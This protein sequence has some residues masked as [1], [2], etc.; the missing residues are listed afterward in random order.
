MTLAPERT[1]RSTHLG[2]DPNSYRSLLT[3]AAEDCALD[4]IREQLSSWLR[5]RGL[6]VDLTQSS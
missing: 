5:P 1:S 4:R 6:E 3:F 2:V